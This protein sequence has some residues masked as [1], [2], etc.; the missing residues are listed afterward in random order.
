MEQIRKFCCLV[1]EPFGFCVRMPMDILMRVWY[2]GG[3]NLLMSGYLKVVPRRNNESDGRQGT[4]N[5]RARK[6]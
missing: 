1:V 6:Y 4:I 5:N 2:H 3:S